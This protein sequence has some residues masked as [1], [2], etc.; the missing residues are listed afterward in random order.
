MTCD[1]P[2][3]EYSD[4]LPDSHD[5][6][7]RSGQLGSANPFEIISTTIVSSTCAR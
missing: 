4:D 6:H 5:G 1:L 2:G 3:L 7:R